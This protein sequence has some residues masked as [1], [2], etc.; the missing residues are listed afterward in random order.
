MVDIELPIF[1][2]TLL[3]LAKKKTK[4]KS[5][6]RNTKTTYKKENKPKNRGKNIIKKY[7]R[8]GP[9]LFSCNVKSASSIFRNSITPKMQLVICNTTHNQIQRKQKK[10]DIKTLSINQKQ[11]QEYS[12][13]E[14]LISKL[15]PTTNKSICN[16]QHR[17]FNHKMKKKAKTI[18]KKI[19]SFDNNKFK[20]INLRKLRFA[21]WTLPK[22]NLV[23]NAQSKIFNQDKK[24][25]LKS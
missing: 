21:N 8:K 12:S 3:I 7:P 15:D 25:I 17:I 18:S 19:T 14:T 9:N 5:K 1:Q 13:Q 11:Y 20:Y 22:K 23:S 6:Q 10:V 24:R 2:L 4:K 16:A